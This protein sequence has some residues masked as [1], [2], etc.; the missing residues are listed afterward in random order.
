[1][2]FW[3]PKITKI[4]FRNM[5][6]NNKN[7]IKEYKKNIIPDETY[8]SAVVEN[9]HDEDISEIPYFLSLGYLLKEIDFECYSSFVYDF[10]KSQVK[11]IVI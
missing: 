8:I 1:M 10:Y 3:P 6:K 7:H 9:Y 5:K 4:L 11:R 2:Y